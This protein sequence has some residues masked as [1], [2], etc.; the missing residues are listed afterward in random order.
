MNQIGVFMVVAANAATSPD[1]IFTLPLARTFPVPVGEKW[2]SGWAEVVGFHVDSN[3]RY[4]IAEY[5]AVYLYHLSDPED[6]D[7]YCRGEMLDDQAALMDPDLY[8]WI[9][10]GVVEIGKPRLSKPVTRIGNVIEYQITTP[11]TMVSVL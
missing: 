4:P 7:S 2:A 9:G 3:N 10:A 8:S 6:S 1:G 5:V 11:V